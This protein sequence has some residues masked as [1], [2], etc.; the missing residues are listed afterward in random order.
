MLPLTFNCKKAFL[1]TTQILVWVCD[2]KTV[3][4]YESD[5][6]NVLYQSASCVHMLST[7]FDVTEAN[8]VP[9]RNV[10][11]HEQLILLTIWTI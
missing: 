2:S 3:K 8:A 10:L 9:L 7:L 5:F 1:T 6:V 11:I 4:E